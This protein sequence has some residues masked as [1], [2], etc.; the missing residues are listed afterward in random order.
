M[1]QSATDIATVVAE[2]ESVL[3]GGRIQKLYQ[4]SPN[5]LTLEI[6]ASGK[7]FTLLLSADPETGRLHLLSR[8][9]ANPASPPAFCQFV[10]AR[11]EGA[12]I[13]RIE[14]VHD[15]RIVRLQLATLQGSKALVLELT[16]RTADLLLLQSDETVLAALNARRSRVGQLYVP[17]P[18]RPGSI[19]GQVLSQSSDRGSSNVVREHPFPISAAIEEA[20]ARQ[21]EARTI[22]R[23][24][25]ARQSE[26]RRR[27]KKT[28]RHLEAL[29]AD[30][31][32][33]AR[34]SNY[35]RYGDLLKANLGTIAK[36]QRDVSVVDYFDPA[37]PQLLIPLD[38]GKSPQGN[39][40]DYFRKHRK[41]LTAQREIVPRVEALRQEL[42]TWQADLSALQQVEWQA[43]AAVLPHGGE[44][45]GES[46]RKFRKTKA[47]SQSTRASKS[48]SGPFRRFTS[49]DGLL[50]YVGR[51]AQENEAVTFGLA[52]SD[53][54]WLHARGVPGSHV[55]VRLERGAEIPFETLRDAATLALLYSDLK[56]S[57]KG[58]VIYTRRKY[59][60]KMKRQPSGTVS[61]T[62]EK[63]LFVQFDKTRLQRLKETQNK[64]EE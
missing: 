24:R 60:R 2:I 43:P 22:E 23:L 5:V 6:R 18:R 57:G 59:V 11:V 41:Y 49:A 13:E 54:V 62:Q 45:S 32:K 27:L 33:A 30:L 1:A 31:E 12:R 51:N 3:T 56:K 26:L 10:R 64:S 28:R 21:E 38:P 37:M 55:V 15:D 63:A 25:A 40:E 50:I 19:L 29:E 58:E 20:Y 44:H 17:P 42:K 53:D 7:T 14:Q 34:Y 35:A 52:H 48:R 46:P 39:M 4:P 16:G 61:V 9:L 36:G 8:R 47:T